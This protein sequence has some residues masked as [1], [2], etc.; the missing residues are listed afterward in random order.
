MFFYLW[1]KEE[2]DLRE[3]DGLYEICYKNNV[4]IILINKMF[5]ELDNGIINVIEEIMDYFFCN[6]DYVVVVEI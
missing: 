2:I 3:M 1:R 6:L 4:E 5:F